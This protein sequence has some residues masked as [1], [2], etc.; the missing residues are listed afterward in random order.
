MLGIF[1]KKKVLHVSHINFLI[2]N[3]VFDSNKMDGINNVVHSLL[4]LFNIY[5]YY[6][7]FLYGRGN[8]VL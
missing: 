3:K 1:S 2:K 6:Y 5:N 4:M 8:G 7:Y